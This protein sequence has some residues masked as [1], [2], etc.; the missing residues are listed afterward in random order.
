MQP[1]W[2]DLW[3]GI[4]VSL[5]IPSLTTITYHRIGDTCPVPLLRRRLRRRVG[6]VAQRIL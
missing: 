4:L 6:S 2:N 1:K 5:P 3:A